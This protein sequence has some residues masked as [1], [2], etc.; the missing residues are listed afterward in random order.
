MQYS[1]KIICI[2]L[3]HNTKL[4]ISSCAPPEQILYSDHITFGG[5][6]IVF[7]VFG[8]FFPLHAKQLLQQLLVDKNEHKEM[9]LRRTLCNLTTT[10]QS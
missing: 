7:L 2:L 4:K 5:L 9:Q 10:S 6:V 3:V 8:G 1:Q